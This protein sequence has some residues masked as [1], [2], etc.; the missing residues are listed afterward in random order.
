MIILTIYFAFTIIYYFCGGLSFDGDNF[1]YP[2]LKW[3]QET[4]KASVVAVGLIILSFV[5]H[6]F[7]CYVKDQSEKLCKKTSKWRPQC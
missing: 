6:V 1:I 7:A 3:E 5:L 4:L 2:V